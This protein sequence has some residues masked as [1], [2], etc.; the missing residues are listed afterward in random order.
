MKGYDKYAINT[1]G[2]PSAVLMETPAEARTAPPS[3]S[4]SSR[5]ARMAVFWRQ[6]Q[7]RRGRFCRRALRPQG[8]IPDTVVFLLRGARLPLRGRPP[9]HGALPVHGRNAPS[10]RKRQG[11]GRV[12]E[13]DIIVDAIF[14]TGLTKEVCGEE[15]A[16][17]EEMNRSGNRSSQW[18]IPASTASQ[19]FRSGMPSERPIRILPDTPSRASPPPG[20]L[21]QGEADCGGISLPPQRRLRSA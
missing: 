4:T 16:V 3:R 6:G 18:I 2:V 9:Q 21:L 11:G 13:G 14:G 7:Q 8:S 15:Q 19:G 17:I 10:R 20:R 1:W 12:R 5:A